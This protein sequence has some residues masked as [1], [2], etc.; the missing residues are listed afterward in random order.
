MD[1]IGR[2]AV[3]AQF[4]AWGALAPLVF[5]PSTAF[6]QQGS[7]LTIT[8]GNR[9]IEIIIPFFPEIPPRGESVS[10]DLTIDSREGGGRYSLRMPTAQLMALAGRITDGRTAMSTRIGR[11]TVRGQFSLGRDGVG[12]GALEV[13]SGGAGTQTGD[14]QT[15]IAPAVVA[16]VVSIV[17]I[18]AGSIVTIVGIVG[19]VAT[20]K[21]IAGAGGGSVS[22]SAET[23]AGDVDVDVEIGDGS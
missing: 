13:V 11:S 21:I 6:S 18:V 15:R 3:M 14:V 5:V 2:R 7:R 8:F 9:R 20:A 10:I 22:V 19:V 17:G 1:D 23:S 12:T 4:A 16:G